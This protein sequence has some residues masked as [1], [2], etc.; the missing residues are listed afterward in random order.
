MVN[1][2][3]NQHGGL[4]VRASL[5]LMTGMLPVVLLLAG[6]GCDSAGSSSARPP[7][8]SAPVADDQAVTAAVNSFCGACHAVPS[9]DSFPR[10][11]W[12]QEVQRG[13]DFYYRSGRK[14]LTVP[15]QSEIVRWYQ[16]RAPELL[17]AAEQTVTESAVHFTAVPMATPGN[18]IDGV[19]AV[20]FVGPI[21]SPDN[22][23][24]QAEGTPIQLLCSD[25][26]SGHVRRMDVTGSLLHDF[27]GIVRHPAAA[28]IADLNQNGQ[29][30][31]ILADLGSPLPEDH[32]RGKVVW[33][34]DYEAAS[35]PVI[36][37]DKVGRVADVRIGDMDGDGDPDVLAAEF[38]WYR[39]G[40]IHLI[41]NQRSADAVS[42]W[43]SERLDSRAGPIH[44]PIVD[45]DRDGRLDFVA[46]VSQEHEVVE[47]FLNR[48]A[49]FERVQLFAGADPSWGSSG[50]ELTDF[51]GDGDDDILYTNGDTFDS[52]LVK[53][54]HAVRL[55]ENTGSLKFEP[56]TLAALPGVHRALPAD[57]DLDGDMDI[58]AAAILPQQT[59]RAARRDDLQAL[60]WLE[61]TAPGEFSR[62]LIQGGSPIYASVFLAD[63]DQ[64]G[65]MDVVAGCFDESKREGALLL[66]VFANSAR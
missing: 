40:G 34:A 10:D 3:Q 58:V 19:A 43:T 25:M 61:Q 29:P 32:D 47:A 23:V 66:H 2:L 26:I 35:T 20:S 57:I 53:P 36:L 16:S 39:T 18:S 56:R 41:R 52:N 17:P 49:S 45:L 27:S 46:L 24:P 13:F 51:D 1:R 63:T 21:D 15:V 6:A 54:Y 4:L 12:Y 38:G 64:D 5:P 44:L 59:L 31:L 7:V 9:P 33:I 11:D 55:L 8:S 14:D 62:H 42:T 65:D 60:I 28:R 48:G 30:D 50:I 37:L 22:P